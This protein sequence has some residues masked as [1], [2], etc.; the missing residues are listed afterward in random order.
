M[1]F[2]V[3]YFLYNMVTVSVASIF[4][5][6]VMRVH[7]KGR[8]GDEPPEWLLKICFLEAKGEHEIDDF[9]KPNKVMNNVI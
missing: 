9:C 5:G 3:S 6:I 8:F 1:Y 7:R 2:L 4:T